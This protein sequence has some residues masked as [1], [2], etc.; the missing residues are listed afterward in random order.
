MMPE[1][2]NEFMCLDIITSL[3]TLCGGLEGISPGSLLRL[4]SLCVLGLSAECKPSML[5]TELFICSKQIDKK[6]YT[7][8]H[9]L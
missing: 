1:Q 5:Q 6:L 4:S 7:I 9:K 8:I 3:A 2:M